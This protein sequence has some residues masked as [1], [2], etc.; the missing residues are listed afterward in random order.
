MHRSDDD[1]IWDLVICITTAAGAVVWLA[2]A[3]LALRYS[4]VLPWNN[5]LIAVAATIM[6]V[7][8]LVTSLGSW[9]QWRD[10]RAS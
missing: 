1:P 2:W 4:A 6:A 9:L 3:A 7:M 5:Q 10:R 8:M